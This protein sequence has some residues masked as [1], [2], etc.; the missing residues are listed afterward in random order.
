MKSKFVQL[1]S[2]S[3]WGSLRS[4]IGD[5]E[6]VG[7]PIWVMANCPDGILREVTVGIS[8]QEVRSYTDH[9]SMSPTYFKVDMWAV[10]IEQFGG[11]GWTNADNF[12]FNPDTIKYR[13]P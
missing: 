5:H 9:G 12:E 10:L 2:I 13:A 7:C 1:T 4:F 11:R 6:L 3:N 8:R